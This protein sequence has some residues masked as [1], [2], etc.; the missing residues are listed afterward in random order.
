MVRRSNSAPV[1][2]TC[3]KFLNAAEQLYIKHGYNG[4]TIRAIAARAE[5]NLGTL[6]HYWGSKE[7]VFTE[8]FER[9]FRPLQ[10]AHLRRLREIDE[11]SRKGKPV[12]VR[13]V[14]RALIEPTFFLHTTP[15]KAQMFHQLYGRVLSDP[16]P[17]MVRVMNDIFA[18]PVELFIKLLQQ[19]LPDVSPAEFR[20]R[21]NCV[22]GAYL[23]Q[24]AFQDRIE[25]FVPSVEAEEADK[26]GWII[27]FLVAG[28]L[29]EQSAGAQSGTADRAG[30]ASTPADTDS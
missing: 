12:D 21:L 27:D 6:H 28:L 18:E 23:F 25:R 8:L 17:E 9:R 5:V 3:R 11:A 1:D 26:A 15:R 22:M 4:T 14:V 24:E 19:A 10:E 20:V 7:A 13:E 30:R 16:A 2:R 29:A